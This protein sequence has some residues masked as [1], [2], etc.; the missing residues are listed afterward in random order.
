MTDV[1]IRTAGKSN[2]RKQSEQLQTTEQE[3]M[4]ESLKGPKSKAS[5]DA[6]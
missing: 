3:F 2:G 6:L 4:P 5:K 1:V